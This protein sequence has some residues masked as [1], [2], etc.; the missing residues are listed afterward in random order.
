MN[1]KTSMIRVTLSLAIALHLAGCNTEKRFE[2]LKPTHT[3]VHFSN[4][5]EETPQMNIFTY[6]YFYNGGGVAAGDLN[7]DGLPD[8]YFTSNLDSNRLYLNKGDFKFE[9]IT[10][11]TNLFGKR[12]WTTGVAMADVN[13][14]GKLDIYVS[15]LGDYKNI[16]GK[17]QLYINQGNDE[18]GIPQFKEEAGKWGLD[19]KGFST[20]AAF[21]D[22]DLDGDLD[23]YM[24]NHSVH[25]NGT[26]ERSDLRGQ[27][28][29]L[30]GDKLMRNDGDKFTDVSHDSGIYSSALGYGLG[31]TIA[32]INWDGYPDI[33]V[34]NDFHEDDYLYIN[35]GDGTF[36]EKLGDMIM[37]TSRFSM[38]NDVADLNNDGLPDI[39]SLDMLPADPEKLKASAGEDAFDVYHLKLNYGYKHQYSR[40]TLQLNL[41]NGKFSEI[42]LLSGIYATD[43]SW[44]SLVADFDLDGYQDIFISNGIK[45]RMNDLDYINFISNDAIQHRLE[46]DLTDAELALVEEM[47]VVKIS[48]YIYRNQG[49]LKF[50]DQSHEWGIDHESFSNGAVYVDLD[51]DGDLDLVTNN[52][53]QPAF[54]YKNNTIDGKKAADEVNFLKVKFNGKAP[55]LLG[56]GA[57][58]VFALETGKIIRENFTTRGFQ[59]TMTPEMIVGLGKQTKIDSLWVIWPDKTFQL[60]QNVATNQTLIVNQAEAKGNYRFNASSETIF[61]KTA[62]PGLD[63]KHQENR[64]IEFNRE[65]LIP[66]MSSTEGPHLMVADL[67]GDGLDDLWLPGAKRVSSSIYLQT[68]NGWKH[69]YQE[70]FRQDSLAEDIMAENLDVDNDG[71]IDLIVI[72][73][74]NEFQKDNAPLRVR[75]YINDGKAN[76]KRDDQVLPEIHVTG[77]CISKGDFDQDGHQDIFIGGSVVPWAYG[78]TPESYLLRNTGGGKFENYSSSTEGLAKV[79]MAKTAVWADLDGDQFPELIVAGEW[80][81]VTVFKNNNGK[82]QKLKNSNLDQFKGWWQSLAVKDV[83]NDGNP[84]IIA[85][86]LGLNSKLKA[87]QDQ[88]VSLYYG[89]FDENQVNEQLLVY[90]RQGKPTLFASKDELIKQMPSLKSKFLKYADYARA[91]L[92]DIFPKSKFD[93]ALQ[94][95]AT[96]LR[97]GVFYNHD[98]NFEFSPLPVE[99]QFSP[100]YALQVI[101]YDLD[102]NFDILGAGNFYDV[103]IQ[104]GRYDAGFGF[105]LRN[106][107]KGNYTWIGNGKSGLNLSGQVRD[108]KAL[109]TVQGTVYVVAGNNDSLRVIKQNSNSAGNLVER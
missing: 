51:N 48:N 4:N 10:A 28:H 26:Y 80:M 32:D 84:D 5:L 65:P 88:P 74:G 63:Y 52:I 11:K 44:S 15:Q 40:N 94:L 41:G 86:N 99:A 39:V 20:Q 33:Y 2:L 23:M 101:D 71:D 77:G 91:D 54:I 106:D 60:L 70:S 37:H 6:L 95:Q 62:Q 64:Y 76:F 46:G 93:A 38:G 57:K 25:S 53:D 69:H 56:V 35:N 68:E 105:L 24:L 82:L 90:Y 75:V 50:K 109:N 96:E 19:L 104:F 72:S 55:N 85:G 16:M 9:D 1:F 67:N 3:G 29:P 47:P 98:G 103:N 43:W 13:G 89:D 79:G 73:G 31:I 87:S 18:N 30:A 21:F 92:Y 107:G 8:L 102:G 17:N 34:G 108:I 7:S 97:S 59:S 12:G 36:S 49:N 27:V 66:H 14:D 83:D 22:Y 42:A 81:P 58:L 78:V 61:S 45:R 100:V